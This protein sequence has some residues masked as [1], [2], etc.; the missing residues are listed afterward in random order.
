MCDVK[1]NFFKTIMEHNLI[2][3]KIPLISNAKRILIEEE[4]EIVIVPRKVVFYD[5]A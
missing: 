4:R 1:F 3:V 2:H 5:A